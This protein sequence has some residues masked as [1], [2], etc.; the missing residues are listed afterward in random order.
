MSSYQTLVTS[1][2]SR[3]QFSQAS[4]EELCIVFIKI[5][6][7]NFG[8]PLAHALFPARPH[9]SFPAAHLHLGPLPSACPMTNRTSLRV[10]SNPK[11]QAHDQQTFE[12]PDVYCLN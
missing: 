5:K 3:V 4:S 2:V 1:G 11:N 6:R 10:T 9:A 7:S 8:V 12:I